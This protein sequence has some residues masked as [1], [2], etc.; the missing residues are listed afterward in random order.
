MSG[1]TGIKQR[2][3]SIQKTLD[4]D[5]VKLDGKEISGFK[6]KTTLRGILLSQLLI[7]IS[8]S[9]LIEININ[10][11]DNKIPLNVVFD[12]NPE[13]SFPSNFTESLSRV[14]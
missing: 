9:I 14:F 1:I 13:I 8:M 4:N 11:C 10:S 6:S 2:Y 7:F 5:S 3:Q 12:L